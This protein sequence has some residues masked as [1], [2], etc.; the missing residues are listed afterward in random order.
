M[1]KNNF[2][3]YNDLIYELYSCTNLEDLKTRFLG[4]IKLLIPFSYASILLADTTDNP[5]SLFR[6]NPLCLPSVFT[7][8]EEEYIR[9]CDEDPLL[10]IIHGKESSLVCESELLPEE[11]RLHTPLYKRC[12]LKYNIY[13]SLQYSIVYQQ[14][15]L[16]VVTLFRTRMDGLF[17]VDDMFFLRSCGIHLNTVINRLLQEDANPAASL[18]DLSRLIQEFHLTPRE[19]EILQLIFRYQTNQEIAASLSIKENTLQKHLQNLFRK[20]NVSSKWELLRL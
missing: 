13:D 16:G 2:L 1:E 8:A 17:S 12:Y 19:A 14:K 20:T 18:R 9:H 5:Q 3:I 11:N 4:R 15:F 7:E 6:E 10:W